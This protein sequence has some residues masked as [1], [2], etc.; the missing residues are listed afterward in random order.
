[1]PH[2]L[3]QEGI[4]FFDSRVGSALT[5][6]LIVGNVVPLLVSFLVWLERRTAAWIQ[7]RKGPNRVGP[8]GLLQS[9]ADLVKFLLKEDVLPDHVDKA[10]FLIA[11]ALAVIPPLVV[12]ALVPFASNFAIADVDAGI[13]A[14]FAFSGIG[15]YAIALGGWASNSKYS[16]IGGVR[17]SAQL[18]SY[19]VCLGLSALGVFVISGTL[20]LEDVVRLQADGLT[21]HGETFGGALP[22]F[23][24]WNIWKQPVGAI[25][26]LVAIFAETNRAPF[27]LPEAESELAAGYHTE[28]SSMKFALYFLGEYAAMVAW[29][30]IFVTIYLGG[31]TLFGAENAFEAG[32]LAQTLLQIA[33]FLAKTMA[34]LFVFIWVRWTVP[35]FRYDQ[36]MH[37]GWKRLLPASLVWFAVTA[38]VAAFVR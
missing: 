23:F 27:D 31:W 18:I 32:G 34:L 12:V 10:M 36:L 15:V 11:P 24:D 25:L 17:A 37:L 8:F 19:E 26:F 4:W 20:R 38:G 13:L 3:A 29:S 30:A 6:V 28:F 22:R 33:I 1:M 5:K 35:R 16:L 9:I 21:I 2:W 7:D 14:A